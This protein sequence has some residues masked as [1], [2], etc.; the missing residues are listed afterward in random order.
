MESFYCYAHTAS[1]G[2]N[3]VS[4]FLFNSNIS[5]DSICEYQL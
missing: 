5:R 3:N 2:F 1:S 4:P